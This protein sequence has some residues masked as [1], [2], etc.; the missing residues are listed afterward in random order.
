MSISVFTKLIDTGIYNGLLF[1]KIPNINIQI[2]PAVLMNMNNN[3]KSWV[4]FVFI[5]L[6]ILKE[7]E[8]FTLLGEVHKIRKEENRYFEK[9]GT[10]LK[11][12]KTNKKK[13]GG[14]PSSTNA[15]NSRY[16]E[17][18][19]QLYEIAF[20]DDNKKRSDVQ[21]SKDFEKIAISE[22]GEEYSLIKMWYDV[23][24]R[25]EAKSVMRKESLRKIDKKIHDRGDSDE[26]SVIETYIAFFDYITQYTYSHN[27]NKYW[28]GS[29]H[30]MTELTC[31]KNIRN[32]FS[33]NGRARSNN[34][35]YNR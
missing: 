2:N 5:T 13:K 8:E 18:D 21:L 4:D 14:S 27:T 34:R 7:L 20:L 25:Y 12:T 28:M 32:I 30:S 31:G 33:E 15:Q 23:I 9:G 16:N 6:V 3:D 22:Y 17:I 24:R 11:K 35:V 19:R 10:N 26:I 29:V 1:S